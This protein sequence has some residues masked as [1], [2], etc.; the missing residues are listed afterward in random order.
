MNYHERFAKEFGPPCDAC[1]TMLVLDDEKERGRCYSC[2]GK[3]GRD[4]WNRA[5][6]VAM[7]L[8]AGALFASAI[9]GQ[10]PATVHN[11]AP[12]P[13]DDAWVTFAVPDVDLPTGR[14]EFAPRRWP[15]FL[16]ARWG[17]KGRLVHVRTT[18][19][20]AVERVVGEIRSASLRGVT[21]ETGTVLEAATEPLIGATSAAPWELLF[22]LEDGGT[23]RW[24]PQTWEVVETGPARVVVH[25]WGRVAKTMFAAHCWFAL[26]T[27]SRS[28][29]FE[30]MLANSDPRTTAL[31]QRV[32]SIDLLTA[33]GIYAILECHEARGG[34]DT[35]AKGAGLCA[36][37]CDSTWWGNGQASAW[38]GKLLFYKDATEAELATLYAETHAPVVGMALGW[39]GHWG[40]WGVT[41]ELHRSEDTDARGHG[42]AKLAELALDFLR[43]RG[44]RGD[45]FRS[46]GFVL[47]RTP[48]DTG[49]QYDFGASKLAPAL[50]VDGGGPSHL[51]TLTPSVLSE[52]CRPSNFH[53]ADGRPLDI[54]SHTF[55]PDVKRLV[56][57][58]LL[59]HWSTNR[60]KDRLGKLPGAR[61][62]HNGGWWVKDWGH[63]S[64]NTLA[65]WTLL[66]G[67][68][69]GRHLCNLEI[70]GS[71][72]FQDM[73][74]LR[75]LGRRPQMDAWNYHAT[76]NEIAL[77]TIDRLWT[78]SWIETAASSTAAVN[79]LI[80]GV[81][82]GRYFKGEVKHW[83]PWHLALAI[84][85]L[86]AAELT[87]PN[88]LA[89]V[90]IKD[91]CRTL[92]E[93]GWWV[94]DSGRWVIGY[95]VE[96]HEGGA[97]PGPDSRRTNHYGTDFDNWAWPAV[98]AA[99]RRCANMPD[100]V[101]RC[102]GILAQLDANWRNG[103][104]K[105][106]WDRSAEWRSSR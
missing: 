10:I 58:G 41:P 97:A 57:Y 69:L 44:R 13:R 29:P 65:G 9:F 74:E 84:T 26:Y 42:N 52:F 72:F 96:W 46:W 80:V 60:S 47:N 83:A 25:G 56:F 90:A 51:W 31:V 77:Q 1:G 78:K 103:K 99:R 15:A 33:A 59:P 93:F 106:A 54:R 36:R 67:S 104:P 48:R 23:S 4:F 76:G 105:G 40:P 2:H 19:L 86:D 50:A 34:S 53:E 102:D 64:S 37:L 43:E 8:L 12:V 101:A 85:G 89:K 28:V 94:E 75:G 49:D 24:R 92:I 6:G 88:D 100:V 22:V 95:A 98:R 35:L 66:T 5:L 63:A 14:L 81:K 27:A 38:R 62:V 91:L 70:S 61:Q 73:G 7:M 30:L 87:R 68:Y 16:G 20:E 21:N 32:K 3:P 11:L 71:H 45:L 39:A 82:D 17:A 79:T 55:P 18:R